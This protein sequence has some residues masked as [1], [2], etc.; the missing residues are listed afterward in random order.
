MFLS[1]KKRLIFTIK[2]VILVVKNRISKCYLGHLRS[3]QRWLWGVSF[4]G[5]WRRV[6][7][8]VA[9]DLSEEHIASIFRVE[10]T[11]QQEPASKHVARLPACWFLWI[12][13]STLKMEAICSSET[14]VLVIWGSFVV[15]A[16]RLEMCALVS[17]MAAWERTTS[18]QCN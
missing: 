6:V 11:I 7:C 9:T 14:S 4:F 16:V 3:L 10:K 2:N 15:W 18:E 1:S 17:N 12:I 8:W 13:S 5:M